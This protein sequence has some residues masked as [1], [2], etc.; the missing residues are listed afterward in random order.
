VPG[1]IFE[2]DDARQ[3][4]AFAAEAELGSLSFWSLNRDRPCGAADAAVSPTCSG[5]SQSLHEFARLFRTF[6]TAT[7]NR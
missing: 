2:Q 5:I 6:P 7:G 4:L 3:L 1:E